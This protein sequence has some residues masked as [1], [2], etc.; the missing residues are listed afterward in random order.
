M[1]VLQLCNLYRQT[2][3]LVLGY[4]LLAPT[5]MRD[6]FKLSWKP[7][8]V[9]TL[10]QF[11][12]HNFLFIFSLSLS[13]S[14]YIYMISWAVGRSHVPLLSGFFFNFINAHDLGRW[15]FF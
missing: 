6:S 10:S 14:I 9:H 11:Y 8:V 12:G 13:L 3:G 7:S 5:D 4:T 15:F 2:L 1:E